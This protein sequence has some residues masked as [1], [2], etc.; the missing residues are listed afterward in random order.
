ME[1]AVVGYE[2]R[3]AAA[4]LQIRRERQRNSLSPQ[5]IQEL[6]ALLGRAEADPAVRVVVLTGAGEKAFC[7]G[8]DLG[9][10]AQEG[11]FL[12]THEARR[13]YGRLLERLSTFPRPTV[14]RVNGHALAGGLGL[15]LACDLAVA[16]EEAQFGTP[17]IDVGLFPMMVMALL[18]RHVGRKRALEW[19]MTGDRFS[20]AEALAAG[21]LSRVVPRA[22]LDAQVDALAAKLA[23]KS[24]AVL[25]LGK[26]AFHAA[27]DLPFGAALELLA[28][29]LSL[30]V[31]AD[32]A[33]EGVTAFLE[34][35]PPAWK[36]Q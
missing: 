13:Q 6:L 3:G 18:Q 22:E 31:L 34:K 29:Q 35:R 14:A 15:V 5:V 17:E 21:L 8:G 25:S 7:A 16:V 4:H 26:R 2:L 24:R 20:A 11:G 36:D 30:N 1:E 27:E 23:G 33:A 32:D 10:M 19:V 9:G 12:G 28:S